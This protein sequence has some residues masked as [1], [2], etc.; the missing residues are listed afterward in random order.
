[1]KLA[2]LALFA[3]IVLFGTSHA[4]LRVGVAHLRQIGGTG[5]SG[6]V[7]FTSVG[8]S[9]VTVQVYVTG[10]VANKLIAIHV[11]EFGDLSDL[12]AGLS[13]G[14][15]L[16]YNNETHGCPETNG[17]TRHTGDMGNWQSDDNGVISESK[18]LDLLQL[19]GMES[20]I[21]R[22]VV[23][24]SDTDDCVVASSA[25]SRQ[26][27]GVIGIANVA[28]NTA[29]MRGSDEDIRAAVCNIIPTS[30]APRNVTG[31]AVFQQMDYYSTM[32]VTAQVLGLAEPHGFHVHE[33]GDLSKSDATSTG[34]HYNPYNSSHAIP[35]IATRHMGDM[36][37]IYHTVE[38]VGWYYHEFEN[39]IK[40]TNNFNVI[41]RAVIVHE[42]KDNCSQPVGFAGKRWGYCVIGIANST[43]AA[44]P[45]PND[46][47]RG[48]DISNCP[49]DP[50][51]DTNVATIQV[52][53]QFAIVL[54]LAI[55]VL[56]NNH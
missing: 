20:I 10:V 25:K 41:G 6:N 3:A 47:P 12:V 50:S 16:N 43:I 54:L 5:V 18:S 38:N 44:V 17:T 34:G 33:F 22:S 55:A 32:F 49:Q 30:D 24:H 45:I 36:G 52:F 51:D 11:H 14:G 7:T 9:N 4:Q 26:A 2:Y 56:F 23:V 21:G 13:A 19:D 31:K 27:F 39:V 53:S 1:M 35:D 28:N 8:D 29:K 15:H 37:N 40:L 42:N 46:T 48:Q